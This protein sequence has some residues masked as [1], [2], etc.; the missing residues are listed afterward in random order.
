M[1]MLRHKRLVWDLILVILDHVVGPTPVEGKQ[2][3]RGRSQRNIIWKL[4][5][6]K[7]R[8]A[9]RVNKLYRPVAEEAVLDDFDDEGSCVFF[10][11]TRVKS[12]PGWREG[13]NVNYIQAAFS[14]K[15]QD[16]DENECET[17]LSSLM[18]CPL[19]QG[20]PVS[21]MRLTKETTPSM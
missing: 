16:G 12:L 6:K 20:S 14:F 21:S 2:K 10:A 19:K 17:H 3:R 4:M 13:E 5:F 15:L 18:V 11:Q 9:T 7:R 8:S 1:H